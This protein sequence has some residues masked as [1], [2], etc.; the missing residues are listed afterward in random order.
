MRYV[1]SI[2]SLPSLCCYTSKVVARF[3][4]FLPPRIQDPY[5]ARRGVHPHDSSGTSTRT[6]YKPPNLVSFD[7][8]LLYTYELSTPTF[9]S[10]RLQFLNCCELS[11]LLCNCGAHISVI[12]LW[13]ATS[14]S[15]PQIKLDARQKST[16]TL[17]PK[18]LSNK[19]CSAFTP[20]PH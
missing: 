3:R 1:L 7:L 13:H 2:V 6:Y 9:F 18:Y 19:H 15:F 11:L 14:L 10:Q 8:L 4:P 5:S 20:I 12:F 17:S 16:F